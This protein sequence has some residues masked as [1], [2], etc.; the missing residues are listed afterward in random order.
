MTLEVSCV[1]ETRGLVAVG[2]RH[3]LR[4]SSAASAALRLYQL[5]KG[6]DYEIEV[7]MVNVFVRR[8]CV[9]VFHWMRQF[10]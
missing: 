3:I 9:T 5:N 8:H 10:G 1:R 6:N 7:F 4:S 2:G